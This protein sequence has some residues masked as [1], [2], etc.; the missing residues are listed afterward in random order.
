MK[1]IRS[2][3]KCKFLL[4]DSLSCEDG[5]LDNSH[6]ECWTPGVDPGFILLHFETARGVVTSDLEK[7]I[8]LNS[9]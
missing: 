1:V 7:L 6:R 5:F 4:V 3:A 9:I 8:R 2:C